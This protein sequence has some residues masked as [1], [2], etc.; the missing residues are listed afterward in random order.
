MVCH[1]DRKRSCP[2]ISPGEVISGGVRSQGPSRGLMGYT[3][4]RRTTFGGDQRGGLP[5]GTSSAISYALEL[6]AG[7]A[8]GCGIPQIPVRHAWAPGRRLA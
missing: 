6:T 1:Q 2:E 7:E 5:E 8:L 3:K 4:S